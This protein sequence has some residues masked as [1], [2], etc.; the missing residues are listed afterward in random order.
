M[1]FDAGGGLLIWKEPRMYVEVLL[2]YLF[3]SIFAVLF[4]VTT[5]LYNPFGPRSIDIP[6][7]KLGTQIRSF[8]KSLNDQQQNDFTSTTPENG[9][10][11]RK[12]DRRLSLGVQ[13]SEHVLL[14]KS[15]LRR[16]SK[17]T[18]FD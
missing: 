6:H 1:S 7:Y 12:K 15:V 16:E 4:D 10:M 5:I 13:Q 18:T 9:E 17:I 14:N 8:A 3:T 2:L 11:M